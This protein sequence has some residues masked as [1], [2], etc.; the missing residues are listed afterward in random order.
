MMDNTEG[1]KRWNFGEFVNDKLDKLD[2]DY[3]SALIK[4]IEAEKEVA[5]QKEIVLKLDGAKDYIKRMFREWSLY[6][7]DT[8]NIRT[9]EQRIRDVA[10]TKKS[11][12]KEII[13]SKFKKKG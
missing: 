2:H 12:I 13:K 6:Q 3:R 5:H 4:Q 8:A 11:S 9:R 1:I 7:K 10:T